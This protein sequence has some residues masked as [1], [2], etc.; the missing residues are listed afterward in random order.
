MNTIIIV[1]SKGVGNAT[2]RTLRITHT[3]KQTHTRI[4]IVCPESSPS[5]STPHSTGQIHVHTYT[6]VG[7]L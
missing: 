2:T 1:A 3:N 7:N 4:T 6:I 5:V